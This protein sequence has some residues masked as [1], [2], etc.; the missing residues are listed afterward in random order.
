MSRLVNVSKLYD[1]A[2]TEH[3]NINNTMSKFINI[4]QKIK[5]Y[6]KNFFSN[7]NQRHVYFFI[8]T[9]FELSFRF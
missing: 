4:N 5:H 7:R 2:K 9:I 8:I 1:C 3:I 6:L